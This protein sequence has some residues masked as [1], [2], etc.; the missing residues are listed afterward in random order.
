VK[1][2]KGSHTLLGLLPLAFRAIKKLDGTRHHAAET[3]LQ[4]AL[5]GFAFI[6]GEHHGTVRVRS[7]AFKLDME[8]AMGK[9]R[10]G[11]NVSLFSLARLMVGSALG[12]LHHIWRHA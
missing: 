3:L 7:R 5:G 11:G 10:V 4:W 2:D 12:L 1:N 9:T 8:A 6:S